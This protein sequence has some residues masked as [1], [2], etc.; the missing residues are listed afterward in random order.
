VKGIN[1]KIAIFCEIL[2]QTKQIL[3]NKKIRRCEQMAK[4]FTGSLAVLIILIILCWPAALIYFLVKY[5]EKAPQYYQPPPGQAPPPPPG[6]APPPAGQ[7]MRT[8]MGS[9]Q[10][11][12]VTFKNCPH[13][14]KAQ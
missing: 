10:Q 13:C 2:N 5:E 7:Q 14:G 1:N 12:P 3:N 11:I 9:G 4:E 8:C 6:Q